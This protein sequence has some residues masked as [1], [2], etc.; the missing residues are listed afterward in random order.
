MRGAV[1]T[2]ALLPTAKALDPVLVAACALA[3][4]ALDGLDG[5]LSRSQRLVSEFGEYFD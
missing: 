3:L 2:L 4:F 1:A 5:W